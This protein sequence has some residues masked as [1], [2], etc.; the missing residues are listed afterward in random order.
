[1][2]A[3]IREFS[4]PACDIL[5][6]PSQRTL[7]SQTRSRRRNPLQ[8]FPETR[9]RM[10]DRFALRL[11]ASLAAVLFLTSSPA[12]AQFTPRPMSDPATGETYHI[13]GAVGLWS[14]SADMS[15]ASESLGQFP[16]TINFKNDLGLMD[17]R[18]PEFHL[19]LRPARKQK[20]RFQFI[21]IDYTQKDHTLSRTIVFN[22]QAYTLGLPVNS[23]LNWKAY[24]FAYEY[25][26]LSRDR[27]FTGFILDAKYTDVKATLQAPPNTDE[28]AHGRAPIPAAGGIVRIYVVPNISITGELTGIKI[29]ATQKYD[30][31]YA[32]LDT[33]ATVNFTNNVGAQVG[34]RDFDIGYRFNAD[35]G[36][37]VLKGFYFGVVARY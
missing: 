5:V 32:D 12:L 14:P 29:P 3:G 8:Q 33:Y 13:E 25:D 10:P 2:P 16:T 34:Y 7:V 21:P 20:L 6:P 9:A 23:E 26:F 27:W 30:G 11:Y 15:I 28:F 18:F 36:S 31:H 35:T 24:R 22:G 4:L 1:M 37:F 19:V 17:T